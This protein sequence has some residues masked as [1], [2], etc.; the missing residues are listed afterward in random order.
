MGPNTV[1]IKQIMETRHYFTTGE[2][3]FCAVFLTWGKRCYVD[4]DDTNF[5]RVV[6]IKEGSL[7]FYRKQYFNFVRAYCRTRYL[8]YTR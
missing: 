4:N 8:L 5:V 1:K 3:Q 2:K 7:A 6:V